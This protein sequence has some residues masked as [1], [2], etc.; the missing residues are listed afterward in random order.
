MLQKTT[1][2]NVRSVTISNAN[3]LSIKWRSKSILNEIEVNKGQLAALNLQAV[4]FCD[5]TKTTF[6]YLCRLFIFRSLEKQNY[7]S[8]I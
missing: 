8:A 2:Q 3:N 5:E 7:L 1:K 4:L 6:F